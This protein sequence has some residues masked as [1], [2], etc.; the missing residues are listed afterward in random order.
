MSAVEKGIY[1]H[2]GRVLARIE[3]GHNTTDVRREAVVNIIQKG[4]LPEGSELLERL[5]KNVTDAWRHLGTVDDS[6][7]DTLAPAKKS[8]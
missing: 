3:N 4:V 2:A 8:R 7:L 1:P 5:H 6:Q